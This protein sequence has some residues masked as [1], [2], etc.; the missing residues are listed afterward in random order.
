MNFDKMQLDI[1]LSQ[2]RDSYAINRFISNR[3]DQVRSTRVGNVFRRS[4]GR[5]GHPD[6]V[7]LTPPH[8]LQLAL[9]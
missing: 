6:Q 1:I 7:I 8:L 4:E 5:G 3:F 9:V 2:S